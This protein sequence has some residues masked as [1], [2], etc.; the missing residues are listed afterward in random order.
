MTGVQTCALP[1]YYQPGKA[2]VVADALSRKSYCNNLMLQQDQ[3]SLCKEFARLNLEIVPRGFLTTLEVKPSLEDQIKEAQEQDDYIANIKKN[4]SSGVDK[5][6]T[7]D[8]KG[9]VYFDNRL[10]VPKKEELK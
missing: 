8:D 5:C 7:T 10:V 9:I 1:I 3:P 4:I 6:F 2:N